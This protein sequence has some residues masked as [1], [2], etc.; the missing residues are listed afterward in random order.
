MNQTPAQQPPKK[1]PLV[2][3]SGNLEEE[4]KV[5]PEIEQHGFEV[6][7]CTDG[8]KALSIQDTKPPL[9]KPGLFLVD[10]VMP[11][12]SSYDL[13]RQLVDKWGDKKVFVF[14]MSQNLS[15]E[16]LMESTSAGAVGI[17]KKPFCWKALDDLFE[18]ERMKRLRSEISEMVFKNDV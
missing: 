8:K 6:I 2:L 7:C 13:V 18:K 3:I 5:V 1:V 14:M 12:M 11:Q 17:L 10:V 9:W 4:K 16:D 15:T